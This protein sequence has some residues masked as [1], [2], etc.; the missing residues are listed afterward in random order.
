MPDLIT[1]ITKRRIGL[2]VDLL[3]IISVIAIFTFLVSLIPLFPNDFWWHL[4]IGEIIYTTG[5]IPRTNMFSWTLGRDYPYVYGAWLGEF[6]FYI[7]YKI[8][9]VPFIVFIRNILALLSFLLI[10]IEAKRRCNSWR[11]AGFVVMIACVIG[12]NNT[13]LRP[14]NF[15]WIPFVIF[16]IFL[17]RFSDK[18]LRPSWLFVLPFTMAFWVN[19]HGSFILGIVLLG[20]FVIGELI[21]KLIKQEGSLEWKQLGWLLVTGF[22]TFLSSLANPEFYKIYIYVNKLVTD[23]SVNSLSLEWKSPVPDSYP[24]IVFFLSILLMIVIFIYTSH[25]ITP[26]E[27]LLILAFIWESWSGVRYVFWY[28]IVVMP[29]LARPIKGLIKKPGWLAVPPPKMVNLIIAIVLF[30]PVIVVQPW[31]VDHLPLPQGY[32]KNVIRNSGFGP[33]LEKYTPIGAAKYL[34]QH[35]GGKLWNDMVFGSFLI[36]YAPEQ[37]IF[38][39]T[40]TELYD[41]PYW[42]D[43]VRVCNGV[44]SIELLEQYGVDRVL[45]NTAGQPELKLL[46]EKNPSWKLEYSDEISQIWKKNQ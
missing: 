37:S 25:R 1:D 15:A 29:I 32:A 31:F 2:G 8:G 13:V 11:I 44:R 46:L 35:P 24:M 34:K 21:R 20:I 33:L 3:W 6:L 36:W 19:V 43:Y 18:A 30:I 4:K 41:Y 7:F 27:I 5:E 12:S 40:R 23:K 22:L 9:G 17:S 10:G 16:Y 38:A 28:G 39:D 45:L 26:T 42:L 14:Q